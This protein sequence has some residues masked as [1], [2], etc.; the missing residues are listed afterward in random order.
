ME[1]EYRIMR[2]TKRTERQK[3]TLIHYEGTGEPNV[4][5]MY[6]TITLED[7]EAVRGRHMG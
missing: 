7:G 6:V 2:H 1:T 4:T 5:R 3:Q